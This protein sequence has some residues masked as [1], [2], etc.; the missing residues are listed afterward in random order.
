MQKKYRTASGGVIVGR[1]R[2][3][4]AEETEDDVEEEEELSEEKEQ[5][6]IDHYPFLRLDANNAVE[7]LHRFR[8]HGQ[9]K[10]AIAEKSDDKK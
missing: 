3:F 5:K 4:S 9:K 7:I 6:G 10:K 1:G 8:L 2:F